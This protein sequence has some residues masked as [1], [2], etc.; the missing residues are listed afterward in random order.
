MPTLVCLILAHIHVCDLMYRT[1]QVLQR[2]PDH[3]T[4]WSR[5]IFYASFVKHLTCIWRPDANCLVDT[6]IF[7]AL[8]KSAL[9]KPILPNLEYL[10]FEGCENFRVSP[11]I[12]A[13]FFGPRLI[14][15][16]VILSSESV[17]ATWTARIQSLQSLKTLRIF[18]HFLLQ[19]NHFTRPVSKLVR[20]LP[21]VKS[22]STSIPLDQ[23]A[24]RHLATS[25]CYS[26][27]L[28]NDAVDVLQSVTGLRSFPNLETLHIVSHDL[29]VVGRL[30][31]HL[32]AE[33]LL[34]IEIA[35]EGDDDLHANITQLFRTIGARSPLKTLESIE[36]M[37]LAESW[38]HF[39][40]HTLGTLAPLFSLSNLTELNVGLAFGF[41]L[42]DDDI[43][44][45]AMAWPCLRSLILMNHQ[46][47]PSRITLASL[48]ALVKHCPELRSFGLRICVT[49]IDFNLIPR[50]GAFAPNDH[51]ES[52]SVYHAFVGELVNP[53]DVAAFLSALFP[54]LLYIEGDYVKPTHHNNFWD[55]VQGLLPHNEE[56]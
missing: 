41:D 42:G 24:L 23:D 22:V 44:Q 9:P 8:A 12:I 53:E 47:G 14:F 48:V 35:F 49:E 13:Q 3:M 56:T 30:L 28:G 25:S 38:S 43:Q 32:C 10:C 6:G 26:I 34:A 45:I 27:Q 33:N 29:D 1:P 51:V 37:D 4:D 21:D 46:D 16:S 2:K 20:S 31:E 50:E 54:M 5:F 11:D 17:S 39:T 40:I 19:A 55:D 36:I 52:I 15:M 18:N 7:R